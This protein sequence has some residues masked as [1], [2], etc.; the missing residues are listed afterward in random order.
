MND[1]ER[2]QLL[3]KIRQGSDALHQAIA[4]VTE[5]QAAFR[6]AGD[7]WSIRDC[8][9]HL[10]LTEDAM[11]ALVTQ[12]RSASDP[13]AANLQRDGMILRG[14]PDRNRKFAAPEMA[15]P[16][17]RFRTLREAVE[18]FD[19]NRVRATE[20]AQGCRDNLRGFTVNH[21]VIGAID[22]YQCMLMIALH[23]VRHAQQ[24]QEV[25]SDAAFPKA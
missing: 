2:A 21:P 12:H 23:P 24:I 22:S 13:A 19:R 17:G 18:R 8:V 25:R 14:M 3:E 7:R 16:T 1:A 6:S 4:G 5:D 9:E 15:Q 20:Y 11:Y 10:V